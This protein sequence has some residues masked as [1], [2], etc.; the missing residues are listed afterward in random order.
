VDGAA[1][2]A[3]RRLQLGVLR[4]CSRAVWAFL[5]FKGWMVFGR[6]VGVLGDFQV[7][8]P[9]RVRVGAHFGIN[10]GVFILGHSGIT[11]GDNVIIS[12]R[13]MLI[14]AGLQR[15]GFGDTSAPTHVGGQ[16]VIGDRVWIGAGAIV[17]A[18][19]TIGSGSI[20]G[21]GSV[22][23]RDVPPNTVVAGNPARPIGRTDLGPARPAGEG[24]ADG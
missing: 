21:A 7:A 19:V 16:I 4:I 1:M 18:N 5:Q 11:I 2:S 10:H 24:A 20:V 13:A 9:V 22:V 8:N 15:A 14:D 17:L 23:T 3:L 12:A 6:R